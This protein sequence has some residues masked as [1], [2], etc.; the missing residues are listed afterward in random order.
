M[1]FFGDFRRGAQTG[2][3]HAVGQGTVA[4]PLGLPR[5]VT[6]REIQ[7]ASHF[8]DLCG[9]SLPTAPPISLSLQLRSWNEALANQESLSLRTSGSTLHF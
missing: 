6:K 2:S 8:L 4:A 5:P 1:S 7:N 9:C 3:R